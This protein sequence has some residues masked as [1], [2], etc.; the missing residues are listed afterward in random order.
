MDAQL[1]EAGVEE[2]RRPCDA[3]VGGQC[4][5]QS[6]ADGCAVDGRDRRQRAVGHREEPV[7][8]PAQPVLGGRTQCGEVRAGTERLAR[9]G[10]D[11]RVH[12]VVGLRGIDRGPQRRRDLGRDRVAAIGIVDGDEGDAVLDMDQYRI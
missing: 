2:G 12:V 6:G 7:V 10:D 11:E 4:E 3:H 9:A 8:D 5:V 1:L